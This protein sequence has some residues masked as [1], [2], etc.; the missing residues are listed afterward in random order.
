MLDDGLGSVGK[1]AEVGEADAINPG[2]QALFGA[3]P[4]E[5]GHIEEKRRVVAHEGAPI[6][7]T[8]REVNAGRWSRASG[9]VLDQ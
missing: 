7:V 3:A 8:L 1:M 9:T 6:S 4:D 2:R 5:A